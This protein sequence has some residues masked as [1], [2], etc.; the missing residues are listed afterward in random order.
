MHYHLG[1]KRVVEKCMA[2]LNFDCL[3]Y[4]ALFSVIFS[5]IDERIYFAFCAAQAILSF[6]QGIYVAKEEHNKASSTALLVFLNIIISCI[7]V[8]TIKDSTTSRII[9]EGSSI[10]LIF[11]QAHYF[12]KSKASSF[13]CTYLI[14]KKYFGLQIGSFIIYYCNYL[15]AQSILHLEMK[16]HSIILAYADTNIVC[17]LILLLMG[18][19]LVFVEGKV[20]ETSKQNII[21]FIYSLGVLFFCVIYS[22]LAYFLFQHKIY[23]SLVISIFILGRF[24]FAFC[25]QFASREGRFYIY[26]LGSISIILLA[27][28][29]YVLK[30]PSISLSL[31]LILA[32]SNL[33]STFAF[34]FINQIKK[35]ILFLR[36]PT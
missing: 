36:R 15:F 8:L 11:V 26:V 23:Y 29:L 24:A 4:I 6:N 3:K 35:N 20:L 25:S 21:A 5:Y 34:L 33:I 27:L 32:S 1:N 2:Y 22:L 30:R 31:F 12:I 7:C 17:G 9:I 19:A 14:V 28:N 16:S 10:F 13:N 18:Q